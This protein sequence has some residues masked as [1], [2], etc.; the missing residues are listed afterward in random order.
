M[1]TERIISEE[2]ETNPE[3]ETPQ[4]NNEEPEIQPQNI[5]DYQNIQ[6]INQPSKCNKNCCCFCCHCFLALLINSL[7]IVIT[8]FEHMAAAEGRIKATI[9]DIFVDISI[10][11]IYV[12]I[13][14]YVFNRKENILNAFTFYQLFTLFWALP[15]LLS[16]LLADKRYYYFGFYQASKGGKFFLILISFIINLAFFGSKRI[17]KE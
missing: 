10:L 9:F 1:S 17:K 15:S 3:L 16:S 14:I 12:L 13:I 8:V 11:F 2:G 7:I 4:E 5:V 6:G